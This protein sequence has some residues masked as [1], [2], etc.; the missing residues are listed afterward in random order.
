[1]RCG[2][3]GKGLFRKWPFPPPPHPTPNLLSLVAQASRLCLG[4]DNIT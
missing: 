1:M 4:D 2:E 3:G